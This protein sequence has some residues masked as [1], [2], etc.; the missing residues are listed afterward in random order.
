M[1]YSP[2]PCLIPAQNV[3][4]REKLL[5]PRTTAGTRR[6]M[7]VCFKSSAFSFLQPALTILLV[8]SVATG[9]S[10]TVSADALTVYS[11]RHYEADDA[12]FRKFTGQTGIKVNVVKAGADELI[13]RMKAEGANSP[14][15]ILITADAG[16][17]ARAK[18]LGLLQPVESPA[19]AGRIP[20]SLRDPE[21]YWFGFT[22][23]ARI[24]VYKPDRVNPSELSTYEALTENRWR[25]R[26]LARSSSN[27]YNQSLLA[28]LIAAH[29]ED[30]AL[31]W[32]KALRANMARPPQGSDRDQI[33]AVAAGLGDVAIVNTYYLGLLAESDDPADRK[34]F[35]SVNIFFPNQDSQQRGVHVNV[36]G[37]GVA[38]AT[39]NKDAAV[40]LLEFLVS[41]EAQRAFSIA[42]CEYP[43]V[44]DVGWSDLQEHWG[45]FRPDPLNLSVLGQLNGLAVRVFNLAGWE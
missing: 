15:D 3:E 35:E 8:A 26:I 17:L 30:E 10:P 6:P 9:I 7:R 44:E 18:E 39:E 45:R 4:Y 42:T 34:A 11:H 1:T 36:S 29:G 21:N 19:L 38:S 33:R 13:E 5:T 28:S 12:L 24:L 2:Q 16:R 37:A 32:A 25:G 20:A 41:D 40:R 23:R 22:Q 27:V 31:A 43:V 14:A